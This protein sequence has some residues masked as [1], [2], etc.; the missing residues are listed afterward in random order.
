MNR[1]CD[2]SPSL[3]AYLESM[4]CAESK[5]MMG[6]VIAIT[7]GDQIDQP[8]VSAQ[9]PAP[10]ASTPSNKRLRPRLKTAL[11]SFYSIKR[12]QLSCSVV[13]VLLSAALTRYHRDDHPR[14]GPRC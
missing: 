13:C 7:K 9:I 3:T 11:A 1:T 10:Q 2:S 14:D 6:V 12:A 4:T 5:G 8:V